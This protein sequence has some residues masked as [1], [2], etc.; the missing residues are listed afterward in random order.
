MGRKK[1]YDRDTLIAQAMEVFYDHGF[2]ETSTQML[3]EELGVNRFSLYAEFGSKQALF[4]AVLKHYN[5]VVLDQ[6]Y[7]PLEAPT[8]SINEIRG[9]F[10]LHEWASKG[11]ALGRGC[12]MC[13]TAV[14]F[15]PVDPTGDGCVQQYFERLSEAF[16][17]ALSNAH[18]NGELRASV[19]LRDEADFFTA[20][21][22]GV[23]VLIRAKAPE[24]IIANATRTAIKHLESLQA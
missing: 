14:E 5:K 10:E 6:T 4:E 7:G 3:V 21:I 15:G 16:Y 11:A 1:N 24:A 13:N 8:A 12:L 20:S 23:T 17:H 22:L 2:A 9:L 18:S 19:A